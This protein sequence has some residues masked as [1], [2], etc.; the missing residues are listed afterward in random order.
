[1]QSMLKLQAARVIC[2]V[3]I[4]GYIPKT[5]GGFFGYICLKN[6]AKTHLKP[7]CIVFFNNMFCYFEVLEPISRALLSIFRYLK[8]W[9][10]S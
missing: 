2:R 6:P 1:M 9:F 7:N 10:L 5:C 8:Y 3:R 4:P